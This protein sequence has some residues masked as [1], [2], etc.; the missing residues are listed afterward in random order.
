MGRFKLP[1]HRE[2]PPPRGVRLVGKDGKVIPKHHDVI[3]TGSQ[4][5]GAGE[6]LHTFQVLVSDEEWTAL[7]SGEL[8][9][10]V[11]HLPGRTQLNVGPHNDIDL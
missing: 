1:W 11:D 7:S 9:V 2:P 10:L 5:D 3:Y 6:V 8:A 4:S